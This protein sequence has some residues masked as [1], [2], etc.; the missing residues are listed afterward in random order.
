MNDGYISLAGLPYQLKGQY[1]FHQEV[2]N[3]SDTG[4]EGSFLRTPTQNKIGLS[5]SKINGVAEAD[6]AIGK[7]RR[8]GTSF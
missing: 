1:G 4:E 7:R 3:A 6:T 5:H 8:G 2:D